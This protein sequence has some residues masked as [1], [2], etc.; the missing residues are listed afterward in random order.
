MEKH[1]LPPVACPCDCTQLE[2]VIPFDEGFPSV[3]CE[4]VFLP[5]VTKRLL[6][7]MEGQNLA[8]E[9][10]YVERQGERIRS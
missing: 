6:W 9:E 1:V 2:L 4:Y 10:I 7:P 8:R 3:C 5:L